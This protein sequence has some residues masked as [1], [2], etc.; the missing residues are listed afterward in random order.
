MGC[1]FIMLELYSCPE[2]IV[3]IVLVKQGGKLQQHDDA[4]LSITY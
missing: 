4:Q 2:F 1:R 3:L